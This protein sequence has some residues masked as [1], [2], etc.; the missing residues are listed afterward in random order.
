[1]SRVRSTLRPEANTPNQKGR[2][3]MPNPDELARELAREAELRLTRG[4]LRHPPM[5]RARVAHELVEHVA[6]LGA[7]IRA[8]R[9][10]AIRALRT[11]DLTW[12]Q[13]G[14][15][16]GVTPQRAQQLAAPTITE[17]SDL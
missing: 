7:T 15:I 12:P 3:P 14:E 4:L 1:M 10:D 11:E 2:R 17:A 13:I 9:S 6:A 16:L 8:I 5:V